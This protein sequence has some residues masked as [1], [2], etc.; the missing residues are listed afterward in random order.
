MFLCLSLLWLFTLVLHCCMFALMRASAHIFVHS[1]CGV[2][3][4]GRVNMSV[5]RL[6]PFVNCV[7]ANKVAINYD[8]KLTLKLLYK[9]RKGIHTHT[10]VE[11]LMSALHKYAQTLDKSRAKTKTSTT[12]T[13]HEK[14]CN[15]KA[16]CFFFS[17]FVCML[18]CNCEKF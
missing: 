17:P 4:C 14:H 11:M 16:N 13:N 5:E 2:F 18:G 10:H 12:T 8:A 1:F 15:H 3:V 7:R 6:L 9:R